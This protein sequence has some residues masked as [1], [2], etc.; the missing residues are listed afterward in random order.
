MAYEDMLRRNDSVNVPALAKAYVKAFQDALM[1]PSH[2]VEEAASESDASSQGGIQ[3]SKKAVSAAAAPAAGQQASASVTL[4]TFKDLMDD[5]RRQLKD[6]NEL[7]DKVQ[8]HIFS[9]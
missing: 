9:F 5:L 7:S 4:K 8:S 3:Q 6:V 2:P 1:P